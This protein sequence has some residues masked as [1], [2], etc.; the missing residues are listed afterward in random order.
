MTASITFSATSTLV[1]G[2]STDPVRLSSPLVVAFAGFAAQMRPVDLIIKP[3]KSV[4]LIEG[5][6]PITYTSLTNWTVTVPRASEAYTIRLTAD[7][8]VFRPKRALALS[9]ATLISV[10]RQSASVV[11]VVAVGGPIDTTAIQTGDSFIIE[12]STDAFTS[13][14]A[15]ANQ[16]LFLPVV[17][18]T[19]TSIDVFDN[20]VLVPDNN[21]DLNGVF[22]QA[23]K[24]LAPGAA[25]N[26]V[27]YIYST[28][29]LYSNQGRFVISVASDNYVEYVSPESVQDSFTS[30]P[31][32]DVVVARD[33]AQYVFL[34]AS[35]SV[36]VLT[37]NQQIGFGTKITSM[38]GSNAVALLTLSS[39][40]LSVHNP[41]L[42]DD[43]RIVAH[44]ASSPAS[45]C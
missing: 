27:L 18:K 3:S 42:V 1:E 17:N 32:G 2:S 4:S 44:V 30:I 45:E 29:P 20:G 39:P 41:S 33:A 5:I 12:K 38:S 13:P 11:R 16:G 6:Q 15:T 14:F 8:A 43:V 28:T 22:G 19:S 21:V 36:E 26:D 10:V 9:N 31:A 40:V 23:M 35:G 24:V 25:L 7:S 37:G 34:T